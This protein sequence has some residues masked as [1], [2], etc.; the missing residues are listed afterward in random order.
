MAGKLN[1][2]RTTLAGGILFLLPLI[3][4]V[5]LLSKALKVAE[6]LSQ[7]V[8]NAI[9]L[10]SFGGV[11]IGTIIAVIAM[12]LV[13]LIAGLLARTRLGHAAYSVLENSILGVLP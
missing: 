1:A 6:R 7:P 5:F 13:S 9:G 12:V 11:A 8:V 10:P 4:V 2:V 3:L